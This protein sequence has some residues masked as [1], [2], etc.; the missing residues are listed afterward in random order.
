MTF[1]LALLA[2]LATNA[3]GG[4]G[5]P[6]PAQPRTTATGPDTVCGYAFAIRLVAGESAVSELGPDFLVVQVA[7]ADGRFT[8]YE[9]NHPQPHDDA[10]RTGVAGAEIVAIHD[11]RPAAAKA[12]SRIRDRILIGDAWRRACAISGRR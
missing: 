1:A 7:A 4:P 9:G 11:G 10:V 5:T 2:L 8:L 12:R 3:Q 6:T